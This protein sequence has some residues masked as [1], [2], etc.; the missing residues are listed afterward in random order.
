ME[1]LQER[2]PSKPRGIL[3]LVL[4]LPK[5]FQI[6]TFKLSDVCKVCINQPWVFI[7]V[8]KYFFMPPYC[9]P[10]P[11]K[12]IGSQTENFLVDQFGKPLK[13]A[14]TELPPVHV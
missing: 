2:N 3:R 9:F 13:T 11:E 6:K 7:L 5:S 10:H 1:E 4:N 12:D 14:E 8:M